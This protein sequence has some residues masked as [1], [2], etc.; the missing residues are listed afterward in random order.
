MPKKK[1]TARTDGRIAVQVYLGHSED[2][3]CKHKPEYS[4]QHKT[5]ER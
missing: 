5:S 4:K 3:K 1:N 2:S